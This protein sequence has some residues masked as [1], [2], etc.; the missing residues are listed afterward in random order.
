MAVE[1]KY[2]DLLGISVG[3]KPDE[4]KKA[5]RKLSLQWHPDKNPDNLEVATERF[6]QVSQAYSVLSDPSTRERYDRYGESGLKQG[7]RPQSDSYSSSGP[8]GAH[9]GG[10]GFHFRP[11][12][13]VFR[14]FF[15]GRDPFSSMFMGPMFSDDPF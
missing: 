11:A 5:Y 9:Q 7:F 13:D 15:G 14:D 1:S 2:Y 8:A 3:A 4:I 10:P 6:Q 12:E